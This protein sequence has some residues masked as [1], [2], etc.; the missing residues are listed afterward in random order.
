MQGALREKSPY[1]KGNLQKK[2][3]PVH[4]RVFTQCDRIPSSIFVS[5]AKG[6]SPFGNA[7]SF[8][9]AGSRLILEI[10]QN[11]VNVPIQHGNSIGK[12]GI[13][14]VIVIIDPLIGIHAGFVPRAAVGI[15]VHIMEE[16]PAH[17]VVALQ[18][19]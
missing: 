16:L 1:F 9:Y 5:N 17:A 8:P 4:F 6:A 13:K 2:T 15:V 11:L 19:L 14:L 12:D 3:P 10:I 7:P 18:E